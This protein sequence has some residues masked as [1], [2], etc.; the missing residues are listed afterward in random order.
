AL[1]VLLHGVF[2]GGED[3]LA[4]LG[5]ADNLVNLVL[6]DAGIFAGGVTGGAIWSIPSQR[7]RTQEL[8]ERLL[9]GH[10]AIPEEPL[11]I[12]ILRHELGG[13]GVD[14]AAAILGDALDEPRHAA[15]IERGDRD[16]RL[17]ADRI[18]DGLLHFP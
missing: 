5:G 1:A 7:L 17:L 8:V 2:V 11:L 10:G 9:N 14:L 15:L 13:G 6:D 4:A 3:T 12:G 16:R 18:E